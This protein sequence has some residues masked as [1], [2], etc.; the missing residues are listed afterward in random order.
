M[1]VFCFVLLI[2]VVVSDRSHKEFQCAY[3][4]DPVTLDGVLN[5]WKHASSIQLADE[6]GKSDNTVIIYSLWDDENLYF[7]FD[8]KDTDLGAQQT[9]DDHPKLYLDDMV[10]FLIDAHNDKGS[11]WNMDDI[12]YHINILGQKKDDRG[13]TSCLTNP[14]WNGDA[15]YSILMNGSINDPTDADKGY[16]VEIRIPWHDLKII[17]FTGQLIGVNFGNGDNGILFDWVD[18]SPF[19][20][21]YAFGNLILS[22]RK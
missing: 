1:H 13:T 5:E 12:I 22:E 10:E 19:R 3:T 21:P 14:A 9:E 18:A 2:S 8:V 6:M 16:V 20:S 15:N 17:P 4:R 11:C 7:S